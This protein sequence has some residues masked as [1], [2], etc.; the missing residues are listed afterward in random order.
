MVWVEKP[1]QANFDGAPMLRLAPFAA[2]HE[3]PCCTCGAENS[4]RAAA[5]SPMLEFA[6]WLMR[7]EELA[8]KTILGAQQWR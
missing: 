4:A 1:L 6:R 3:G 5:L 2:A 7:E 8:T